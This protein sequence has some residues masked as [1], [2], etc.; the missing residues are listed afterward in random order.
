MYILSMYCCTQ[1]M[2]PMCIRLPVWFGYT[3]RTPRSHN[4]C[5]I[6]Y[7][8]FV[9]CATF[10]YPSN[11]FDVTRCPIDSVSLRD[12]LECGTQWCVRLQRFRTIHISLR[13]YKIYEEQMI[14]AGAG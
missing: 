9:V 1:H 3:I 13:I 14:V 12:G 4:I 2:H 5:Y 7:G 6:K 11:E 8:M 10:S